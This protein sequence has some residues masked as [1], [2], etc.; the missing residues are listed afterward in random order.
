MPSNNPSNNPLARKKKLTGAEYRLRVFPV[1]NDR[2]ATPTIAVVVETTKE[3]VNFHYEVLLN[4]QK[5]GTT[6]TLKILG[7]HTPLSVMPGVGP[8]RSFRTYEHRSGAI[9]LV[10]HS[11]DG[12]ENVYVLT[13]RSAAIEVI[14][15]PANPFILFS[16]QPV[17][18]PE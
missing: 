14:E 10:V 18:L 4:D 13:R 3:F 17:A 2:S 1:L 11:P 5:I 6:I 12:D 16:T 8:A 15:A 9:K 7:L